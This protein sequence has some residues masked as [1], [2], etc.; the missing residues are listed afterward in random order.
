[1]R[2]GVRSS[3]ADRDVLMV[4]GRRRSIILLGCLFCSLSVQGAWGTG[5][6]VREYAVQKFL[7]QRD[8]WLKRSFPTDDAA[9]DRDVWGL[10]FP[11]CSGPP[12]ALP[13]Q[14]RCERNQ[15]TV[16]AATVP[17]CKRQFIMAHKRTLNGSM[18]VNFRNFCK[19]NVS[20]SESNGGL[21]ETGRGSVRPRLPEARALRLAYALLVH[22]DEPHWRIYRILSLVHNEHDLFFVHVDYTPNYRASDVEIEEASSAAAKAIR[23]L[24]QRFIQAGNVRVEFVFDQTWGG[25]SALNSELA[26]AEALTSM[27]DWDYFINLASS[28]VPLHPRKKLVE[29]LTRQYGKLFGWSAPWSSFPFQFLECEGHL[30][31][32]ARSRYPAGIDWWG[33]TAWFAYHK[34]FLAFVTEC[35]AAHDGTFGADPTDGS[36]C[37][38]VTHLLDTAQQRPAFEE[39]FFQTLARSSS[40]CAQYENQDLRHMR[41]IGESEKRGGEGLK[42]CGPRAEV[43]GGCWKSPKWL[44][45]GDYE[46]SA[47]KYP[48]RFFSRKYRDPAAYDAA[49]R[50]LQIDSTDGMSDDLKEAMAKVA[51]KEAMDSLKEAA[52]EAAAANDAAAVNLARLAI[53]NGRQHFQSGRPH[54]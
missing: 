37:G 29:F 53:A 41:G 3:C 52:V 27:G 30:F 24:L 45:A 6:Q 22:V 18:P 14:L 51:A 46:A 48:T 5:E 17:E 1:M 9:L 44:T 8:E 28:D 39:V 4:M 38:L 25:V 21:C 43:D 7:R 19:R 13:G 31:R 15:S 11:P 42:G 50:N 36:E 33:G 20:D 10:P 2:A 49:D 23:G 16:R 54:S 12:G 34:T 47:S 40:F 26:A 35:L 32:L